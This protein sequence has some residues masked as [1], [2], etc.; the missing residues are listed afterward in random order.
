[1][2]R[3]YLF[4]PWYNNTVLIFLDFSAVL[5]H[6]VHALIYKPRVKIKWQRQ[7]R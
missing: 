3:F 7:N 6:N 1:M 2:G 4:V 5:G